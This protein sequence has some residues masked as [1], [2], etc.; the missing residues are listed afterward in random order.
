MACSQTI[1]GYTYDNCFSSKGGIKAI[2]IAPYGSN[3]T[4]STES[5]VTALGTGWKKYEVRKETSSMESTATIDAANGTNFVETDATLVFVKMNAEARLEA[6][7][8]LKGDF[9]V[10][11]Q[12]ANDVY[13][14]LGFDEP[15]NAS[16]YSASTGTARSDSNN[17][18]V[19]LHDIASN[20]PLILTADAIAQLSA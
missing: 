18:T 3:Y 7:A 4:G 2:Y 11:V 17:Y 5:G 16:D 20:I 14:A 13:H 12:D 1:S 9:A 15:V 10:I 6:N 19:T 8:L